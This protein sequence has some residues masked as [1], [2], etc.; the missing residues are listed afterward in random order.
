MSPDVSDVSMV[1]FDGV[2]LVPC[3]VQ[4]HGSGDVLMVAY[5]NRESLQ[6]TLET[7]YTWFWSRSREGLEEGATSGLC[8]CAQAALRL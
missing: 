8:A 1:K 6:K 3:V 2:G 4:E 7:G 5:M